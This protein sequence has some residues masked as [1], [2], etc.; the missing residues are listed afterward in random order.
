MGLKQETVGHGTPIIYL[1]LRTSQNGQIVLIKPLMVIGFTGTLTLTGVPKSPGEYADT[2][3]TRS[4][5]GFT[6]TMF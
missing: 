5:S 4:E 1:T 6:F 2:L 3:S